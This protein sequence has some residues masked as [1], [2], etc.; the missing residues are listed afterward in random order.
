VFDTF[1]PAIETLQQHA[2]QTMDAM[3]R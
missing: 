2:G 3:R 1:N